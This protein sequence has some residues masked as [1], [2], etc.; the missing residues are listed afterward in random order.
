[1]LDIA[2][3]LSVRQCTWVVSVLAFVTC[4]VNFFKLH[5]VEAGGEVLGDNLTCGSP[6]VRIILPS[7]GF[8]I[9]RAYE[10]DRWAWVKALTKGMMRRRPCKAHTLLL[11]CLRLVHEPLDLSEG[12]GTFAG[13]CRGKAFSVTYPSRQCAGVS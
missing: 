9:L 13:S 6:V 3:F 2:G 10:Y 8:G 7:E 4:R 11:H 1:M 12:R 5:R